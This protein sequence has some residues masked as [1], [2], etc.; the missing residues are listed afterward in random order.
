[1]PN[2]G[3]SVHPL[4]LYSR[5]S[6]NINRELEN[7]KHKPSKDEIEVER[8][9]DSID[10]LSNNKTKNKGVTKAM[11]TYVDAFSNYSLTTATSMSVLSDLVHLG[12]ASAEGMRG[13]GLIFFA[14]I[15]ASATYFGDKEIRKKRN[16]KND[17]DWSL[18]SIRHPSKIFRRNSTK[19][20]V[21]KHTFS[22]DN[23]IDKLKQEYSKSLENFISSKDASRNK[24]YDRLNSLVFAKECLDNYEMNAMGKK[25]GFLESSKVDFKH[26]IELF[27]INHKN[28]PNAIDKMKHEIHLLKNEHNRLGRE[29]VKE[30][31]QFERT[32][33][34]LQLIEV[35]SVF[36]K[37][38]KIKNP[39][40]RA[41][42]LISGMKTVGD[43]LGFSG[44]IGVLAAPPTAPVTLPVF[45]AG[46]AVRASSVLAN[47]LKSK[48][49]ERRAKK[50]GAM[51][52][53]IDGEIVANN[54][55]LISKFF[56]PIIAEKTPETFKMLTQAI[57]EVEKRDELSKRHDTNL[58]DDFR[59]S[60]EERIVERFEIILNNEL[61]KNPTLRLEWNNLE[62]D[63]NLQKSKIESAYNQR[64]LRIF[65]KRSADQISHFL[66]KKASSLKEI[67]SAKNLDEAVDSLIDAKNLSS[68]LSL[69][70]IHKTGIK[71][72]EFIQ[73][74]IEAQEKTEASR[75]S[76]TAK[77]TNDLNI[78]SM[79][80]EMTEKMNR[81]LESGKSN[82]HA[83][84]YLAHEMETKIMQKL[85]DAQ[86]IAEK[87]AGVNETVLLKN[88]IGKC[89]E[90][91]LTK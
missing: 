26:G 21:I 36:E 55:E 69:I 38:Q 13:V 56:D 72:S 75:H 42:N 83:A 63:W 35:Y 1:M 20:N 48:I 88:R 30:I 6:D 80:L 57:R 15:D 24:L 40:E 91:A 9:C 67:E 34:K 16:L 82:E 50:A 8:F 32:I 65:S 51:S 73:K 53:A 45:G 49:D 27:T 74:S 18:K 44:M 59:N 64:D 60:L 19:D 25:F 54:T 28:I 46:I 7:S 37:L 70:G 76:T 23:V 81:L 71:P 14:G 66:M 5:R 86:K 77:M 78:S 58:H 62:S 90:V 47:F 17:L 68:F 2:L 87:N 22:N 29:E 89:I 3:D 43:C 11:E 61:P 84:T 31:R 85:N 41:A 12:A 4:Y 52:Q 33:Q 79:L 10:K 39:N